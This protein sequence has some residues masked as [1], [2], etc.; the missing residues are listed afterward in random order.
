MI[1]D[2]LRDDSTLHQNMAGVWVYA[3][4]LLAVDFV[5]PPGATTEAALLKRHMAA[6]CTA[7]EA[8]EIIRKRLNAALAEAS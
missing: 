7:S 6:G 8:Y 2:R 3:V 4:P 5:L 1:G